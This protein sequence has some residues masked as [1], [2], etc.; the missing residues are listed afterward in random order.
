MANNND[1]ISESCRDVTSL[2]KTSSIVPVPTRGW[3]SALSDFR[4]VMS[5]SRTMEIFER[6][7][8]AA[9]G[10]LDPPA[11]HLPGRVWCG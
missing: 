4:S 10:S 9:G 7:E 2:W 8:L 11:V 1:L 5:T 6:L 3:T